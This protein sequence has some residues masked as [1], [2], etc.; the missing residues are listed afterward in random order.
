MRYIIRTRVQ[1]VE[2]RFNTRYVSGHGKDAVFESVSLGWFALFDGSQELLFLGVDQP[3]LKRGDAVK[4]TIETVNENDQP[5][6]SSE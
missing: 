1:A 6:R 3:E 2:E 5:K 4:I